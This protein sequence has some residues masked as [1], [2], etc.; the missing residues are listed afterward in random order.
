MD[1]N[2]AWGTAHLA[3]VAHNVRGDD[4]SARLGASSIDKWG[5]A[6]DA[7]VSFN[8]PQHGWQRDRHHRRLV[9][10]CD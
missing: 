4:E 6:I 3:G 9:A 1:V 5:W 8:I 7:G 2:Q 10:E